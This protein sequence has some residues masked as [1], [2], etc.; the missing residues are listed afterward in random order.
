MLRLPLFDQLSGV[1]N[2][3][4][5]GAGGGF[6]LFSGL[7]LMAA[8]SARGAT[9]HLCSLSF[10]YLGATDARHLGAGVYEVTA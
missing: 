6:D 3:L 1:R 10:T 2:V 9:V 5:A 7:P 8:L 4:V